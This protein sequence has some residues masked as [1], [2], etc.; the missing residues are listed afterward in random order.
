MPSKNKQVKVLL[1]PEQFAKLEQ[2]AEAKGISKAEWIR[3]KI[4]ATFDD[5]RQPQQKKVEKS[6]SPEVLYELKKIG[7]NINQLATRANV[8]K[9]LDR[10]II[11]S[12]V[13]IENELKAL[14]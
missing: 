7:N 5:V 12:L 13:R 9:E 3:Q 14:L 2:F 11:S 1:K 10:Q 8:N 6:L 4:G